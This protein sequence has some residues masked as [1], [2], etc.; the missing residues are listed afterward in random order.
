MYARVGTYDVPENRGDAVREAFRSALAEIRHL[1][2]FQDALLLLGCDGNRAMTI[3]FWDSSNSMSG[4]RVVASRLRGDAARTVDGD[5]FAVE[6][7]E[8]VPLDQ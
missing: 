3:T 4:S 1:P 8:V 5:V 7:Y 6:E 2:G